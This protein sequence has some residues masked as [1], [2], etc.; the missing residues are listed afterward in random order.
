M[1][2]LLTDTKLR[3][4]ILCVCKQPQDNNSSLGFRNKNVGKTK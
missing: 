4:H 1:P 3:A 2:T